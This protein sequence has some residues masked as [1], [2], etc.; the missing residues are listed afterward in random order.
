MSS[1][2]YG[3]VREKE[4]LRVCEIYWKKEKPLGYLYV[5]R[6][7][8]TLLHWWGV[9]RD[10]LMIISDLYSQKKHYHIIDESEFNPK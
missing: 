7:N 2:C 10:I 8:K 4:R 1:W 6:D 9:I 3:L 5:F